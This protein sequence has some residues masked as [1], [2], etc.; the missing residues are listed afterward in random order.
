MRGSFLWRNRVVLTTGA[1]LIFALHMLS[2]GVRPGARASKPSMLLME[3]LKPFQ[4]VEAEMS[5]DASGFLHNYF[6]LVGVRQ[7]NLQ[8]KQQIAVLEGQ[9]A[10]MAEL[11]VENHHLGD[12]LELRDA[13]ALP[14]IAADVI[15]S[16]ATGLSRTLVL[17]EGENQGLRRDMAVISTD[18]VV[19][20]LIAVSRGASRVLLI[21]DHN[22]A[23]DAF[24]QRSRARGIVAGVVEDGLTM[25]Y[26]DRA[27]DIK[28]GDTIVT[29]GMDGIFPRGLLVGQVARVSQEGPGLFLNIEVK[30]A[31]DFRKL[32][33]LLI[34]TTRPPVPSVEGNG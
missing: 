21:N 17:S 16:D 20:K 15:G 9:R 26:V 30:A 34:L 12:L 11:E 18:G 28:P 33:Q 7:E 6:D 8:L 23:L 4:L 1:L 5:D 2:A 10:R 3:A 19:G 24:D 22:S 14:A 31:V 29:S 25:K 32:E 13:L 27:E